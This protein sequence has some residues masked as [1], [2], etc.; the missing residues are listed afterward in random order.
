MIGIHLAGLRGSLKVND[1]EAR[2]LAR[3]VRAVF[4]SLEQKNEPILATQAKMLYHQ[5][6]EKREKNEQQDK[7]V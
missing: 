3:K 2:S 4:L 1:H 7:K 6:L 5:I